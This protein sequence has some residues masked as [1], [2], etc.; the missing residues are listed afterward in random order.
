MTNEELAKRDYVMLID[1]SGSMGTKHKGGR[2]RFQYAQE[3]TEALARKCAEFDADGIDVILF[4][5]SVK[6]YTGVTPEKVTQVFKESEPSG[7][8]ATDAALK[9]VFD[10]YFK[11]KTAGTA[12]PVTVLCITDGEPNDPKA[13]AKVI[14]EASKKID[15]DEE[16]AVTFIQVGDDEGARKFLQSLDDDLEAQGAKF[17]IVDTKN[18]EEMDNMSLTEILIEA[19]N[20]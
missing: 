19:V 8:T 6:V 1:R 2:T 13:V 11:K 14:V 5:N 16:L 12:K 17:D 7:G 15:A 20:G 10:E 4:N 3:Q 9:H 18:E